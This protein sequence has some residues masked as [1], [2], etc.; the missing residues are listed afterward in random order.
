M[1]YYVCKRE[2]C[3]A[4]FIFSEPW[5]TELDE[6]ITT[7]KILHGDKGA[8]FCERGRILVDMDDNEICYYDFT[9]TAGFSHDFTSHN[10]SGTPC[11]EKDC[12]H[13]TK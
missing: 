11:T 6:A 1:K 2:Q 8:I 10:K 4:R 12:A 13:F 9:C 7:M 5:F 3:K